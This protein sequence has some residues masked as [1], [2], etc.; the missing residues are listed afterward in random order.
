[1]DLRLLGIVLVPDL[2][3][4]TPPFVESVVPG[5]AAARIWPPGRRSPAQPPAAAIP[6]ACPALP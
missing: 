4:R 2:L 3:D 6:S 5:S 1:L